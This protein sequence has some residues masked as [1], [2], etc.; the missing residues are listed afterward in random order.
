MAHP[1]PIHFTDLQARDA[2]SWTEDRILDLRK[3]PEMELEGPG[4]QALEGVLAQLL[5]SGPPGTHEL[6][7]LFVA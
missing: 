4:L 6:L 7:V 1:I 5:F 2:C 3:C